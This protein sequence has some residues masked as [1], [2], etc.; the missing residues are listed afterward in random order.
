MFITNSNDSLEVRGNYFIVVFT[1]VH[2]AMLEILAPLLKNYISKGQKI[3]LD[4]LKMKDNIAD[5][6]MDVDKYFLPVQ[7]LTANS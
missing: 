4:F 6:A 5:S 1:V 3:E 2:I 7:P